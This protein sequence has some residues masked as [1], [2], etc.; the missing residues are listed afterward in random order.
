MNEKKRIPLI[1][2]IASLID[3]GLGFVYCGAVR[4]GVI[5]TASFLIAVALL[6]LL[7]ALKSFTT[8][9][10]MVCCYLGARLYFIIAS[11]LLAKKKSPIALTRFNRWYAYGAYILLTAIGSF[12]VGSLS[13]TNSYHVPTAGMEPAIEAGDYI[14]ADMNHYNSHG[15]KAGDIVVFYHPEDPRQP[16]VKRCIALGGETVEIRDGLAFVDGNRSLP[17]LFLK[18]GSQSIK[19][20]DFKDPRIYP[21]DSGNEDQ[22]GPVTIPEGKLFMLGDYRDNSLDS[23]YFG[24][25]DRSAVVGKAVYVYWSNDL[26]RVGKSLQWQNNDN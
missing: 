1:A 22:Y 14:M 5:I 4:K 8:A 23:R 11:F 9:F 21:P 12:V 7:S 17:T 24:F 13:P 20:R 19:P 10:I 25:V 15:V 18:R 6:F 16:Y 3:P 26:S 2:G